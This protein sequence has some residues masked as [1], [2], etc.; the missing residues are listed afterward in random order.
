[1]AWSLEPARASCSNPAAASRTC[2]RWKTSPA[3]P[4]K[5]NAIA[6]VKFIHIAST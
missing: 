6:R 4:F 2:K 3:V 5:R 1:M